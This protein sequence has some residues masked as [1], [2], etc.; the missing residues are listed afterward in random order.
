MFLCACFVSLVIDPTSEVYLYLCL[1]SANKRVDYCALYLQIMGV[2]GVAPCAATW[3]A[4]NVQP[5]YRRATA[6]AGSLVMTNFGG[7]VSTWLFTDPPRFHKAAS[8]NLA[9]SLSLVAS[10]FIIWFYFRTLNEKRHREVQHL[11]ETQGKGTEPGGWDSLEA[12]RRLGDRHPRFKFT[13]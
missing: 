9:F 7:I 13:L 12:R 3:N 5:H 11:L 6:I 2:Y 4:N 8:V 10:C 1:G